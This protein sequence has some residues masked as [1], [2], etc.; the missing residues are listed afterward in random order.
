MGTRGEFLA[1]GGPE[2]PE[3]QPSPGLTWLGIPARVSSSL[4]DSLLL[5]ESSSGFLALPARGR[6]PLLTGGARCPAFPGVEAALLPGDSL[7][8][9]GKALTW[10]GFTEGFTWNKGME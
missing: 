10:G 6:A 2:D 3:R 9:A 7:A 1:A 4:S 5:S 8:G